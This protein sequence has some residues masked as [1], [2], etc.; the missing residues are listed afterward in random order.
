MPILPDRGLSDPGEAR[1]AARCNGCAGY[2]CNAG[3]VAV[4]AARKRRSRR[5]LRL[6]WT[7][8]NRILEHYSIAVDA[9]G[10]ARYECTG[11]VAEDSEEQP[12]RTEFQCRRGIAS[13]S[14]SGRNRRG[15]LPGQIDSGNRKLAFT[16]T[17]VLSYQDGAAVQHGASITIRSSAAVQQL[18][19]LFQNM[20]SAHW[21]MGGGWLTTI[22]IRSWR[23][24]T[25]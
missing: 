6:R 1:L 17:K 21:N 25:S 16:G 23:W 22:A 7:F 18:T 8:P 3:V 15:I 2:G 5:W 12:Y 10:H 9:A 13:G 19:A 24:M 11:K 4:T 14:S 20:A